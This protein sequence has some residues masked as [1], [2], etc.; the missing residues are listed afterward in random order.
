MRKSTST[1]SVLDRVLRILH[2]EDDPLDRRMVQQAFAD[3]KVEVQFTDVDNEADFIGALSRASFDLIL[4]DKSLGGFDGLTALHYVRAMY[5]NLPFVF[6]SGSMGEEMAIETMRSGA[7]DYVLKNRLIRLVPAVMRA[8]REAEFAAKNREVEEQNR[9][10]AALLNVSQ[11]AIFMID[12]QDH[13]LF[14]NKTAERLYGWN[15]T[16]VIG[17]EAPG[18]LPTDPVKYLEA[19]QEVLK[20]GTWAGELVALNRAGSKL[21]VESRWTLVR[22]EAGDPK[23]ILITDTDI[24]EKKAVEARFLRSQRMDS[25]GA[26]AGGIAHDLNNALAPVIMSAEL[27]KDD[28]DEAVRHKFLDI[29]HANA[30]RATGL[31]KQILSFARGTGGP[32]EPLQLG[33]LIGEMKKMIQETF[34]KSIELSVKIPSKEL[35]IIEADLTEI[36]QVLLN[37]CVNARDAMPQGGKLTISAENLHIEKGFTVEKV[38]SGPYVKISVA[39][40]GTGIPVD[41]L[42]RIFEPFFTTK[43][44]DKGTGLGLATVCGIVK[45]HGGFMDVQTEVGKGTEFRVYLPALVSA[46]AAEVPLKKEE[47][48]AGHGELILLIDDE[49]TL[50]ELTKTMLESS[51]YRVVTAQNGV[52]G[53]AQFQQRRNDIRLVVTDTDMPKLDGIGAIRAIKTLSPDIPVIVASGSVRNPASFAGIDSTRLKNLSK[54][55]SIGQLLVAIDMSIHN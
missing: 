38:A 50:L 54:P 45:H 11:D 35:R 47:P 23:R 9:E 28:P 4:S 7:T 33:P 13:I 37:L 22:D 29:I 31:V 18:L 27:L 39:D 16:A 43:E 26:L 44:G 48:P 14:W 55:Y 25:I 49:E 21:I 2:L 20:K 17:H 46:A 19:K 53:I 34:P 8:I 5:P 51:G 30:Q 6:V 52:Q 1:S 15:A 36:H 12:V 3:Q 32:R 10:Q 40:T 42:P 24:T 41:V